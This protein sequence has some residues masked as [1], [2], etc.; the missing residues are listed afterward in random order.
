MVGIL[1]FYSNVSW[2][3]KMK[4]WIGNNVYPVLCDACQGTKLVLQDETMSTF[5]D[6]IYT[7]ESFPN[8]VDYQ[9]Q[10]LY[11]HPLN[12]DISLQQLH[13]DLLSFIPS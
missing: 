13:L 9:C 6:I 11:P 12:I 5:T 4:T 3:M 10:V 8:D 1:N 2:N 7:D